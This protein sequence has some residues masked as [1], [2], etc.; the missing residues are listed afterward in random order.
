MVDFHAVWCG[1]C[2]AIAPFVSEL[3]EKYTDVTFVK[4]D[5]DELP[6]VAQEADVTAMPT[7]AFYKGGEK[8][9]EMV[10]AK[11]DRLEELVQQHK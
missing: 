2:K 5:V 10:G 6:D 3:S 8:I 11:K 7:F 4:V 1:P 9:A